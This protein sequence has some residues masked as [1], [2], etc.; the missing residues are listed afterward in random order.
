M[1][2]WGQAEF[3]GL[4]LRTFNGILQPLYGKDARDEPF[5]ERATALH[6]AMVE[7]L[8][9]S[10]EASARLSHAIS[11][12]TADKDARIASLERE[13]A[14]E[15]H[16]FTARISDLEGRLAEQHDSGERK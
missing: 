8:Y 10:Q 4:A 7:R 1:L 13:I 3:V 12:L 5:L 11:S 15:R 6:R 16:S 14:A 9:E 2:P